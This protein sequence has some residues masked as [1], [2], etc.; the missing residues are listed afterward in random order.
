MQELAKNG[1][2]KLAGQE[3]IGLVDPKTIPVGANNPVH[4]EISFDIGQIDY[5]TAYVAFDDA[6]SPQF[7]IPEEVLKKRGTD[8]QFRLESTGLEYSHE[9]REKF[10][11]SFKNTR[12][13]D[14]TLVSSKGGSF[15]MMDKY[16]QIDLTLP[17]QRLYGFGERNREFNLGEG[18]WTMWANGQETPYDD[19]TG[20]K[21]T[22]GHP[23]LLVQT[24]SDKHEFF[25]IYFRNTNA[26]SPVIKFNEDG[27]STLSYITTGGNL[28]MYFFFKGTAKEIIS[29][30]QNFIGLPALPPFWSLGWHASSYGYDNMEKF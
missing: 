10:S 12:F 9:D 2:L 11:F 14:E 5:R 26:Q 3:P 21:Q 22:Y 29:R 7:K 6:K 19:G 25:G 18:T 30:Y 27:G 15:L 28:E 23:F 1:E 20:G 8:L 17:T 16:T 13:P 24:K 4:P